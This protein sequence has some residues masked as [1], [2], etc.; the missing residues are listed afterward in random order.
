MGVIYDLLSHVNISTIFKRKFCLFNPLTVKIRLIFIQETV[1]SRYIFLVVLGLISLIS[2]SIMFSMCSV[3][4]N[5]I[6][7]KLK[8]FL[9][10]Y[11]MYKFQIKQKILFPFHSFVTTFRHT[12]SWHHELSIFCRSDIPFW[13]FIYRIFIKRRTKIREEK[14][15]NN[16]FVLIDGFRFRSQSFVPSFSTVHLCL[17]VSKD[18]VQEKE[19]RQSRVGSIS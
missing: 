3:P 12:I 8:N 4:R 2:F 13:P 7:P 1:N 15:K 19:D 5:H 17:L 14:T 6:G 10:N 18:H 11:D 16:W 9:I